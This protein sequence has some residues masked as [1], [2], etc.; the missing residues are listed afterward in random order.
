MEKPAK[1]LSKE[2]E[3]LSWKTLSTE[4]LA[5]C[6]IFAV[7][8]V[9]AASRSVEEK[10]GRF[11]TLDCASWVNIIAITD[12]AEVLLVRQF[13]H[14]IADLTL[15]IPGG[16]VDSTDA[17]PLS[18]AVRELR[19]ETG[20][21]AERWS[22]LGKNHPNPAM[23]NN[24]CYTFLAEGVS[25]VEAP[26][27]DSTGTEQILNSKVPL[28]NINTLIRSGIITHSL[29]ITAFHYLMLERP[30]LLRAALVPQSRAAQ[31]I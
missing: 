27:F 25:Q 4:L 26:R 19:E 29:V 20:S 28:T 1:N 30:E 6:K 31:P 10:K 8:R 9:I 21:V 3:F 11:F 13:R 15:E 17:D 5:D 7:N 2:L 18:A 23:Q 12:H 14:G 22:Y 24:L 16:C